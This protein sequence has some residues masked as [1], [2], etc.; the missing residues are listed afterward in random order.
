MASSTTQQ[1]QDH[2][3]RSAESHIGFAKCEKSKADIY[4]GMDGESYQKLAAACDAASAAHTQRAQEFIDFGKSLK[5]E[6]TVTSE[7]RLGSNDLQAAMFGEMG[8]KI[9]PDKVRGSFP[10]PV[11]AKTVLVPRTGSAPVDTT[12]V[13]PEFLELIKVD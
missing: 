12:N 1:L 9:V 10:E 5:D 3:A 2:C 11:P 8:D 4:R 7:T 6:P 13:P